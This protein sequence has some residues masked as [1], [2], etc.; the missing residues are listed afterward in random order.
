MNCDTRLNQEPF[1]MIK[2]DVKNIE[3]RL[4]EEKRQ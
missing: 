3:Y 4:N 1:Y 2:S